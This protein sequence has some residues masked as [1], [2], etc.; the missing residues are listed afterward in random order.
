LSQLIYPLF[1]VV[2]VADPAGLAAVA[3]WAGRIKTAG[4]DQPNIS[5]ARNIG[6][7]R[8]AGDV[9]AFIDD[10]AVAEPTWL[11]H[12]ISPFSETDIDAAGGLTLG[13]DGIT[14][15]GQFSWVTAEARTE[16]L[17]L[18]GAILTGTPGRGVKTEGTNMAFRRE[19][20]VDLGGFD[21]AY[22]FYLDETDLNLRLAARGARTAL[23]PSA[24]VHHGLAASPRRRDDRVPLT[25][26]DVGR[27]LRH[28]AE[29]HLGQAD[30]QVL[31]RETAERRLGLIRQMVAGRIEPRD[32]RRLLATLADGWATPTTAPAVPAAAP[33]PFLPFPT[34]AA[35]PCVI[36]GRPWQAGRKRA[37]AARAVA[38]GHSPVT[39][40]LF[41]PTSRAHRVVFDPSG[42]WEHRGGLFAQP[43]PA[44]P[45]KPSASFRRRLAAERGRL[46]GLRPTGAKS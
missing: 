37:Q 13:R 21:P 46:V 5:V 15:Q 30:P 1:E 11:D 12:L 4:Y 9:I 10:D 2:V 33:A 38:E 40:F 19:T 26:V 20:L 32:I 7:G 45:V 34:V 41:S 6:I 28:F 22:A 35:R 36:A 8:A 17:P 16:V 29:T 39:L 31:A 23:V 43:T 25:L 42:F 44:H 14:P 3:R 27:S 18:A 24:V